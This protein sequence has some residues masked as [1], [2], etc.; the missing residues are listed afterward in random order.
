MHTPVRQGDRVNTPHG[1][2]N[3][4]YVR[5]NPPDFTTIAAVSVVL[6]SKRSNPSYTG[7]IMP[8]EHVTKETR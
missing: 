8:A 7:T 3:V 6:D 4:A 1:A 5:M 2:G